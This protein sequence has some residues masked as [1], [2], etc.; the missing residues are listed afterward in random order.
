MKVL[1]YIKEAAEKY[2]EQEV[3]Y[4]VLSVPSNFNDVQRQEIKERAASAG[5]EAV[6]M[7]YEASLAVI[8]YGLDKH[9]TER[10]IIVCDLGSQSYDVT[11]IN[12]DSYVQETIA[13]VSD[14]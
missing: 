14:T 3:K 1:S 10:N 9:E 2:L 8:S 12:V 6:R 11:F 13:S 7:I 4:V 5:L